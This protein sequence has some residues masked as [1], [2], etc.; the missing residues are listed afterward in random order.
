MDGLSKLSLGLLHNTPLLAVESG[1]VGGH[2][3][4][5]DDTNSIEQLET[6]QLSKK[7]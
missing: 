7:Q 1:R 3:D 2:F 5:E 4:E 6:W